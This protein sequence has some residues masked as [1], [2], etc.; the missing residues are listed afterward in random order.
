MNSSPTEDSREDFSAVR[1]ERII[2]VGRVDEA[3]VA[4]AVVATFA[5]TGASNVLGTR[6]DLPGIAMGYMDSHLKQAYRLTRPDDD[7][8]RSQRVERSIRRCNDH[9]AD[10]LR[11]I[12]H[13]NHGRVAHA[14]R[15]CTNHRGSRG[16]GRHSSVRYRRDIRRGA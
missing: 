6:P 4:G 12:R 5:V 11:R 1:D 2:E 10:L 13:R 7:R 8:L 14:S 16:V 9:T 15:Y 3:E